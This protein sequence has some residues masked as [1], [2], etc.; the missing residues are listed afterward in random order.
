M[1]E[2]KYWVWLIF[3]IHLNDDNIFV[4]FGSR[5]T[6][7]LGLPIHLELMEDQTNVADEVSVT[8]TFSVLD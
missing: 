1:P 3:C 8:L 5:L 4:I 7:K 6:E 2:K